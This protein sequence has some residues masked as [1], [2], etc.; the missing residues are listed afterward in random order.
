M[1]RYTILNLCLLALLCFSCEQ[2]EPEAVVI[3]QG[4]EVVTFRATT[5]VQTRATETDL[6]M[7][8]IRVIA[9]GYG[10]GATNQSK[11][12]SAVA[13]A[14]T[15]AEGE[16][17]RWSA[18]NMVFTS[19]YEGDGS[20]TGTGWTM[21]EL[22]GT[23]TVDFTENLENLIGAYE[24]EDYV[25]VPKIPEIELIYKHLVAKVDITL[26][27]IATGASIPA[28]TTIT[29]PAI[30][31]TGVFTAGLTGWPTVSLGKAGNELSYT[32]TPDNGEGK[33]TCYM[34]PMTAN[35][36]LMYGSFTVREAG[37]ATSYVGT[38]QGLELETGKGIEAGIH[39]TFTIEVN[40]DHTALLQA[41][42]LAPWEVNPRNIYNR[43][44]NGIWGLEDL[45]ALSKFVNGETTEVNKDGDPTW[46]NLTMK[47]LYIEEADG[48][49][50]INLY[51]D[52][53]FKTTDEFAAIGKAG[54]PFAGY[55]FN[56][57]GYT[58]SNLALKQ[59]GADNQALF[60]LVGDGT[61]I[62]NLTVSR[63]SVEGNNNAGMLVGQT[64]GTNIIIDHCFVSGGEVLGI[65][66]AG[67]VIG[68]CGAGTIVRNCGAT[69]SAVTGNQYV[70]GFVGQNN[71]TIGNSYSQTG[72]II[73][74]DEIGGG[75]VGQNNN[76]VH[77]CYSSASFSYGQKS[78]GA[79]AGHHVAGTKTMESCH[80]N[81]ECINNT[82]C[83]KVVGNSTENAD[84]VEVKPGGFSGVAF[85][86]N[87]GEVVQNDYRPLY[88]IMNNFVDSNP[89]DLEYLRWT[90]I[91]NVPLPVFSY[92][93]PIK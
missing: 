54:H 30:K 8:D 53:A 39:Y 80:W 70:G 45:Q 61:T 83:S 55:E 60:G 23:G 76:M 49:K 62:K 56:G 44:S 17:I 67:G 47:D 48:K 86:K 77:N 59:P 31:Q 65:H 34:P 1:K 4:D 9:P 46:N 79:F 26:K 5:G 92:S 13:G 58:I 28:G 42:T 82:T 52:I 29:Y 18:K 19:W 16:E 43:P 6:N 93:Y 87:N 35:E 27:N 91:N 57:N 21:P 15:I 50:I 81:T 25:R 14:M 22:G 33:L 10:T 89:T 2:D 3:P 24:T 11:L 72:S 84:G 68:L 40:N 64:S 88:D 32:F 41:V 78:I 36:L 51:T 66:N 75:F 71:G 74:S 69:P 20:T 37:N 7:P 85:A 73:C 12:Y 63:A 38:L 90:R